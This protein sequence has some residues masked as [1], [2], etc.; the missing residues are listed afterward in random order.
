[1]NISS[2]GSAI[3]VIGTDFIQSSSK[4]NV[5]G[6]FLNPERSTIFQGSRVHCR[7]TY[8]AEDV[9]EGICFFHSAFLALMAKQ[10]STLAV[11]R[12]AEVCTYW[13]LSLGSHL[14]SFYQLHMFSKEHEAG[15]ERQSQLEKGFL[16]WGYKKDPTDFEWS[17]WS[18]WARKSLLWTLLGHAVVSR[19]ASFF[20]PKFRVTALLAYGLLAACGALGTKGVGVVLGHLGLSLAVAQLCNP[21]LSWSCALLLL[22]TLHIPQ[23]Q[24]IQ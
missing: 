11:L 23:L 22:S 14:Y 15:L 17:F 5:G 21:A 6:D 18:H 13:V 9:A 3:Y 24:E 10:S 19:L 16:I 12:R 20:I 8:K 2:N 1:M 7:P 4:E